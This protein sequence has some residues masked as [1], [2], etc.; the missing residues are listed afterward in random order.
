VSS[1]GQGLNWNNDNSNT[2][3]STHLHKDHALYRQQYL[4]QAAAAG[5]PLAGLITSMPCAQK[6][7]THLAVCSTAQHSTAR[8]T[9]AMKVTG[10]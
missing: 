9:S 8:D 3:G 7:Q 1:P 10:Q 5:V 4:K 6:G 2:I